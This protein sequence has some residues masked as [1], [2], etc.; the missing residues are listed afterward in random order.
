MNDN[1]CQMKS[2]TMTTGN[3]FSHIN[4]YSYLTM[5]ELNICANWYLQVKTLRCA[6]FF[7]DDG[8]QIFDAS[9]KISFKT[10]LK[11]I[12]YVRF[13]SKVEINIKEYVIKE[14]TFMD[15]AKCWYKKFNDEFF[16]AVSLKV[17]VITV[18]RQLFIVS[19][20][21]WCISMVTCVNP[22][23][24]LQSLLSLSFEQ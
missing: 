5:H 16:Y 7:H 24:H 21:K 2:L 8:Y 22:R 13:Q 9:S 18:G 3:C 23:I 15:R 12:L 19:L 1:E 6:V 4:I 10:I 11:E 14:F 20:G 17:F